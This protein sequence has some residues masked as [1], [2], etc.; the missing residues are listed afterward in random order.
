SITHHVNLRPSRAPVGRKEIALWNRVRPIRLGVDP[1]DLAAKVVHVA[2]GLLCVPGRST[3][4]FVY[5]S[6]SVGYEGVGVVAE[7][8]KQV[9]LGSERKRPARVAALGALCRDLE[10]N[11]LGRQIELGSV[12]RE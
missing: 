3:R 2:R 10:E 8:G 9:A 5:R 12:H 6:E 11:T 4:P 1:Q 7:R